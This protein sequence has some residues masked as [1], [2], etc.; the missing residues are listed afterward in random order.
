MWDEGLRVG[1]YQLVGKEDRRRRGC[2]AQRVLV[3]GEGRGEKRSDEEMERERRRPDKG[4]E[5]D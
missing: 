2:V 3:V 5:R 1:R 4:R